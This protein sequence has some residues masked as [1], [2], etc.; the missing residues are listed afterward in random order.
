MPTAEYAMPLTALIASQ[1]LPARER[2]AWLSH[3]EGLDADAQ[4]AHRARVGQLTEV[5]ALE[6]GMDAL[7]ARLLRQAAPLHDIGE[8]EPADAAEPHWPLARDEERRRLHAQPR[9][10]AALL[11]GSSQPLFTLAAEIALNHHERWDG[12]GYP[13]GL[14]GEAIPLSGR[15]VA[16]V[17]Y[18]DALTMHR[19]YRPASA[20]DRALAMLS[21]QAGS[22]F[23]PA[24]VKAFLARAAELISL[25]DRIDATR[26]GARA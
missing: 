19:R 21:E 15:I 7:K 20:D 23:D 17:D 9:R 3:G 26:P 16:V 2:A 1:A 4:A 5:L 11:A 13:H 24:V 18:F 8:P 10:G 12:S 22:A 14:A 25:R 6:L